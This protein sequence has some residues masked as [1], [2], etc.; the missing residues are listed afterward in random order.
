MA[1]QWRGV[2][3]EYADRLDVTDKT[4]II[5]LGEGGT[6]LIFASA[7]SARTGA[8]VWVKYEG[9]NP[10]GSFKDRG[11]TMA[12]SKAVE[13]GAKAV[14]CAST[15]NTSA[16][17]AA[18]ATHAGITAAVLVPEG[19]I[20]MGKLA[21]AIAHNAQLIQV[22]GNF[23]DCLDMARELAANYPVHL[24]NSV[25]NDRIEGQKTAAFEIVE[26]LEDA[27]DFHFIPVGN[28]GNYT[29]YT[30]GY[31]EE[32]ERGISTKLPRMFGFQAAGSAPLVTGEIVKHPETVASA[33]RIGNPASWELALAAREATDGYFGAIEDAKILEAQR[34]LSQEVGIFVEPASA[35]SVAGLLER[36]EAGQVPADSTVVLTVTGHGLKD[37]QWALRNADGG[38]IA[39]TIVPVDV[40]EVAGVLGLAKASA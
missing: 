26:V 16:S 20:A 24:V 1:K 38:E 34:I 33:I 2:L 35:I 40:T 4:P 18:Y 6:P 36:A 28:A 23:D 9:M 31:T 7:L 10:T 32:L 17:A 13:A 12:V 39:P 22:Q 37:P 15:G 8:K 5:S 14:I 11:M 25:N 27:P 3:H 30:R 21:Q 19:K 29:A